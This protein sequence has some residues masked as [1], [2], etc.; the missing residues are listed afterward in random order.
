M[1]VTQPSTRT[2]PSSPPSCAKPM[3]PSYEPPAVLFQGV[4]ETRAG[5]PIGQPFDLFSDPGNPLSQP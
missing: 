4:I 1:K 5:S 2:P 3:P